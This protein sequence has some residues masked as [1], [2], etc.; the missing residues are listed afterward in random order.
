[1]E[2]FGFIFVIFKQLWHVNTKARLDCDLFCIRGK[3]KVL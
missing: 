3:N 1:M 2:L